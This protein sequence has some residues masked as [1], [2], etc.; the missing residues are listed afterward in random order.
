MDYDAYDLGIT[1]GD[2]PLMEKGQP[3][4]FDAKAASKYLTETTAVHGTVY[5][6]IGLGSGPG[7]GSAWVRHLG[8]TIL[9]CSLPIGVNICEGLVVVAQ[10]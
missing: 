6:T 5:I 10:Q 1:L 7:K 9:P 4:E 3:L 8:A 2:I